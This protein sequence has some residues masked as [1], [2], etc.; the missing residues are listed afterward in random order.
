MIESGQYLEYCRRYIMMNPVRAGIV[1]QI[2]AY[3]WVWSD[4]TTENEV[5]LGFNPK[6]EGK[7]AQVGSGKIFGSL[8]FVMRWIGEMGFAAKRT[9][10]HAV[11]N[12]GYSSHGWRLAKQDVAEAMESSHTDVA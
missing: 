1:T 3:R 5:F 7:V 4:L 11:G 10:A 9:V 12:I 2:N 6:G 8:G